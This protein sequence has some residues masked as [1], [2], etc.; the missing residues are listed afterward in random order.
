MEGKIYQ[1]IIKAMNEVNS[2]SK[3]NY[4]KIQNFKFRGIDDV[5]NT[6]H[7]ILSKNNIFVAPEVESFER[8]ERTSKN[9]GLIIYT[10]ATIKLTFYAEDG[11]NIIVKVVGE[12]MD[13]GDKGMNKAMSIAY[14]YALF[15]VFCIPTEDDPDKDSYTLTPKQQTNKNT[16]TSQLAKQTAKQ[17]TP[18]QNLITK[19]QK[20]TLINL[21]E[22]AGL[23]LTN[24]LPKINSLTVD[25]YDKAL[26]YYTNLVF[27]KNTK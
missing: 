5:M 14:K 20:E 2:I 19:E 15:Q 25:R 18:R 1:N 24:E 22:S 12:A 16:K 26:D 13:S 21:I 9:G 6:M 4:N 27:D 23:I 10:V 11:S 3:D 8:E 7:P 17:Q